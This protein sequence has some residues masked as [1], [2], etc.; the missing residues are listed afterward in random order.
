MLESSPQ[1]IEIKP[2]IENMKRPRELDVTT[3]M[4]E[5]NCYFVHT[6]QVTKNLNVSENNKALDTQKLTAADKLDILYAGNPTLSVSTLRPNTQDGTFYGGFGVLFSQGEV[7]SANPSDDGTIAKSL[8]EREIIGGAK[9][10]VKDIDKAIDRKHLDNGKSYN[11]IVL[12]DPEVAGGFMKIDGEAYKN[13]ISFE[14]ESMTY[15]DRE[16]VRKYGVLDLR[17]EKN[18]A[19]FDTPFS[20]LLEMKSR[21]PVFLLDE[22]NQMLQITNIDE[23]TRKLS[24]SLKPNTPA[25]I[26]EVYGEQ[27]LN[28]YSR[29]E[30]LSRLSSREIK[31][32]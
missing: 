13:K 7:V 18:G 11:E 16:S 12:K 19:I 29:Q 17:N 32:D 24:F 26:A 31:L 1:N 3:L 6:I 20:I 22:N 28:K 27:K 10:S 4:K 8:T 2:E 23:Q 14:E 30:M 25:D 15:G 5:K 9:N 21:G